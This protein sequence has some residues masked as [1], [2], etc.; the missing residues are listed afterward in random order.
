MVHRYVCM[1]EGAAHIVIVVDHR[2]V[3]MIEFA[4]NAVIVVDH[5]YVRMED[6]EDIAVIVVVLGFALMTKINLRAL[7]A[8]PTSAASTENFEKR[9]QHVAVP[10]VLTASFQPNVPFVIKNN[11]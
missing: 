10:F 11:K 7:F 1:I 5:R 6:S 2:Y 8:A 3:Y 4:I 9:V